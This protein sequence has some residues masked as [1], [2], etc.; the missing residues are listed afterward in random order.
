M[1]RLEPAETFDQAI[2]G[3]ASR[4]GQPDILAYSA[5]LVIEALIKDGMTEEEAEEY[6]DYN[7]LGSWVGDETPIFIFSCTI[8]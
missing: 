7:I 2:I 5:E 4:I 3:T 1:I 8:G 6:F